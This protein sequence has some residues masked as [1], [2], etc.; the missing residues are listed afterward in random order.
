MLPETRLAARFHRACSRAAQT[1]R[2]KAV[3]FMPINLQESRLPDDAP[4]GLL[5]VGGEP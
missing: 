5:A 2:A 4:G 3:R 1:T